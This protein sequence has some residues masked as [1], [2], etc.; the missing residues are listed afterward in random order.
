MSRGAAQMALGEFDAA[1][2]DFSLV[3]KN[4]PK[5]ERAHYFNGVALV[6]LGKYEEAIDALTKSLIQNNNR[7]IAH[8]LRGL[9]YAETGQDSDATL[10]INSASAFSSAEFDSFKNLFG[11]LPEGMFKNSRSL[12]S[13]KN[14]PWNNLL[15]TESQEMLLKPSIRNDK[16]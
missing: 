13:R 2:I 11:T 8:L 3:L 16:A 15:N 12:L 4:D 1:N 9:A 6:A 7:G 14:A 10:D 5:N